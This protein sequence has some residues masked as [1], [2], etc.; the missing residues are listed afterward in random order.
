M[1]GR[2]LAYWRG[3]LAGAPT[4]LELPAD[5]PRPA[6]ASLRGAGRRRLLGAPEAA[7]LHQV[8]R[9]E[10][11]TLYMLLLAAFAATLARHGGQEDVLV[12]TPVAN[13]TRPELEGLIGFFVNTLVLRVRLAGDPDF[14][15]VLASVRQT[16]LAAFAHQDLPFEALVEE[17]RPERDLSRAPLVQ[18]MLS[19]GRAAP[20]RPLGGGLHLARLPSPEK[21]TAKLDL[22]LGA[23]ELTEL[24][25]E[26]GGQSL[27]LELEYATDLFTA[28][29]AERF[30]AHFA[31][32][33]CG[34]AE[35]PE[36]PLSRLPLLAPAERH[37]LV[38]EWNDT[39]SGFPER[40]L[41]GLFAEQA[42]ARPDAVAVSW[43]A[44]E[45][46]YGEL[47]RR[48]GEIARHLRRLGVAPDAIDAR[49]ALVTERS[50]EMVAA[51]LGILKAGG[52]Y[53]PLDPSY[54]RERLA[55]L[56]ADAAPAAVVGPR[57]LLAAL[58]DVPIGPDGAPRLAFEDAL[59]EADAGAHR[60]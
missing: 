60:P 49:V 27:L 13:R 50:P 43:E 54:P 55:L 52:G 26:D 14:H 35:A 8:A 31:T 57:H 58:P 38:A 22:S 33:L 10:G 47:D 15:R 48:S 11:A 56:L 51:L 40:T 9:R 4:A 1:L 3:Q 36:L 12:A 20:E 16:A 23:T 37:Q 6:V 44:G 42:A 21:T 19:L 45:M 46:S 2:Q 32:L 30:L 24:E 5:R 28:T 7:R 59:S 41:H 53:L 18:A 34:A 39:A 29:A 17:L 25:G